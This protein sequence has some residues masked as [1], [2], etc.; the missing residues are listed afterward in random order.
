ME[1][2]YL[3][4]NQIDKKKWDN[5]IELSP[6]GKAYV[7]SWYLDAIFPNWSALV[8]EDYSYIFPLTINSQFG[9]PYFFT[10]IYG[11]QFGI[12]SQLEITEEI[13][14]KFWE[15]IIKKTK[16]IDISLH[17][18]MRYVPK[19]TKILQ[20]QCQIVNL[21]PS[22]SEISTKY[23]SN[24]KRNLVKAT[25][26]NLKIVSSTQIQDV[27]YMFRNGRGNK[28]ADLKEV[29]YSNL[30]ALIQNGIDANKVKI[31]ECYEDREI[32]AAGF[33]SFCNNRIIYHKGGANHKGRKYGAMHLII[34]HI[35]RTYANSGMTMDFG[36]SS[37]ENVKKFNFNFTHDEYIY[38]VFKKSNL[39]LTLGRNIKNKITKVK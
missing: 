31:F 3:E 34:D 12:F 20:K 16:A 22:Y 33:F 36:G 39:I 14:S 4:S 9:I 28:L 25:K 30:E 26:L 32:I 35:I 24:L 17:N 5:I 37:I 23:N 7:Y 27:V 8:T 38:P 10:P 29:H 21:S 13:E 11:M 2:I 6:F 19:G 1:I 15:L 18:G